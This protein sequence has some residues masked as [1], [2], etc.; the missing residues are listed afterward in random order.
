M[1]SAGLNSLDELDALEELERK[2]HEEE[3]TRRE[4]QLPVFTSEVS[5]LADTL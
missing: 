1:I 5:A 4:S 2:E 3:E